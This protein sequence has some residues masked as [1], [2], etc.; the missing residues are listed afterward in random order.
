MLVHLV[1]ADMKTSHGE[2]AAI[3]CSRVLEEPEFTTILQLYCLSNA[4]VMLAM[5]FTKLEA[6]NMVRVTGCGVA[7]GTGVG[8]AVGVAVGVVDDFGVGEGVAVG[9]PGVGVVEAVGAGDGVG[10]ILELGE[11]VPL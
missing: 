1:S 10:E 5:T 4:A 2:P 7:V 11:S 8:D 9:V 3:C 6:A